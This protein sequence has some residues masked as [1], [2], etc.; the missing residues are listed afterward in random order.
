MHILGLPVFET[1]YGV[2]Q[3]HVLGLPSFTML[4]LGYLVYAS[5]PLGRLGALCL[6]AFIHNDI[7]VL[8]LSTLIYLP[9]FIHTKLPVL[10]LFTLLLFTEGRGAF[11]S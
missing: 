10:S 1:M 7:P 4:Y 3:A 2:Y 11:V 5:E 8:P 6:V 9:T